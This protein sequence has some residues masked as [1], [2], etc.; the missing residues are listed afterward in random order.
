MFGWTEVVYSTRGWLVQSGE[1]ALRLVWIKARELSL[2]GLR[3]STR[4]V[5]VGELS[6]VGLRA[7]TRVVVVGELSLVGLR[8]FTRVVVVGATRL[9]G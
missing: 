8:A 9:A 3:S 5:V 7:S 2:V 4:V 6:L 1:F